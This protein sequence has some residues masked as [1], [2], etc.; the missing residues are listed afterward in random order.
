MIPIAEQ[1]TGAIVGVLGYKRPSESEERMLLFNNE[2][3][4]ITFN[5]VLVQKLK[6]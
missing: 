6:C 5:V 1:K 4:E 3:F 2:T